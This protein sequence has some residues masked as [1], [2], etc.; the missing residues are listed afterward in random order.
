MPFTTPLPQG[1]DHLFV[2]RTQAGQYVRLGSPPQNDLTEATFFRSMAE[3]D[4]YAPS[5]VAKY[6][7]LDV[8][9]VSLTGHISTITK[10]PPDSE[11]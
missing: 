10:R 5:L 9:P 11:F 7:K 3:V 6:G 1:A 4:Q 2:L 8:V